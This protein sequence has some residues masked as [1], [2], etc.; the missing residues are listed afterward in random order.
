LKC[1]ETVR[2]NCTHQGKTFLAGI[3]K[4]KIKGDKIKTDTGIEFSNILNQNHKHE[5]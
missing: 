2:E 4:C 5:G 3:M 1:K